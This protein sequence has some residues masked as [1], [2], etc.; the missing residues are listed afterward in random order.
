MPGGPHDVTAVFCSLG[1]EL[2]G[3]I[4]APLAQ[5]P[6]MSRGSQTL[7]QLS[8]ETPSPGKDE[9]QPMRLLSPESASRETGAAWPPKKN[10][11]L[12]ENSSWSPAEALRVGGGTEHRRIF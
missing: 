8:E 9:G 7:V 6:Q 3:P 10:P 4:K 1:S 11:T 5:P 2:I 12:G